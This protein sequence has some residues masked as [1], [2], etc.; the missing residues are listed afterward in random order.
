MFWQSSHVMSPTTFI[1]EAHVSREG[2]PKRLVQGP[3]NDGAPR[4]T[5][6]LDQFVHS[7]D[8]HVEVVG[9]LPDAR[10]RAVAIHITSFH[11]VL[12]PGVPILQRQQL[13]EWPLPVRIAFVPVQEYC[14]T[15]PMIT[16]CHKESVSP[17][18]SVC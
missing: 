7:L 2:P 4:D 15:V 8:V 5:M 13:K 9:L 3:L 16:G 17:I 10:A 1:P 12:L 18:H 11:C 6:H 14:L